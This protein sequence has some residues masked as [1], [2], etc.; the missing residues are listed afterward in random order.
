VF[1]TTGGGCIITGDFNAKSVLWRSPGSDWRGLVLERWAAELDLRI[2]NVGNTPTCVRHNGSSI[3][4]LTW[5]SANIC[6]LI[7]DWCVLSDVLSLSDH[8]Y[9]TFSF[10]E[11]VGGHTG[12]CARYFRWNTKTLDKEL[13][14]EI[15]QGNS[16]GSVKAVFPQNPLRDFRC[17]SRGSCPVHATSRLKN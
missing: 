4:D 11:D 9:I 8:R 14:R 10:G 16:S 5:S 15:V 7:S 17:V 3:I 13:F 1:R 2:M 12:K 6:G